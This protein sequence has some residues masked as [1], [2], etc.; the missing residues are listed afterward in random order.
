MSWREVGWV[1]F[2]AG[3]PFA[4][5]LFR[6]LDLWHAQALW[7]QGWAVGLWAISLGKSN[8]VLRPN[9]GLAGFVCWV[10]LYSLFIWVN[11]MKTSKT[12]PLPLLGSLT[13]LLLI[14]FLYQSALT[15]W[16][17]PFIEKLLRVM[18]WVGVIL[19]VYGGLQLLNLD[20]F[21]RGLGTGP[22][23]TKDS[24]VG[25]IGNPSHF[26]VQL[27]MFIPLFLLQPG[28]FWIGCAGA[29]WSLLV[30]TNSIS[31]VVA[32]WLVLGWIIW[33]QARWWGWVG[34][35]GLIGLVGFVIVWTHPSL[36]NP[37]GRWA[38]WTAFGELF[39]KQPLTGFGSGFVMSLSTQTPHG[40]PIFQWRHVHNEY[41][42]VAIEYGLIGLTFI[43]WMIRDLIRDVW[44]LPKT[45]L[46]TA[47]TG[48]LIAFGM[49]AFINF[50]AHL[51]QVGSYALVA[52]CGIRLLAQE[53]V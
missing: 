9:P 8:R 50:P 23:D 15:T 47:L 19:I 30:L 32:G 13:H 21:F 25:T 27:A 12:Y 46:V 2:L 53:P 7:A 44:Q 28:W 34:L 35:W 1:V 17:Q 37:H 14:I 39:A 5:F 43:G 42:Q 26:A 4:H 22:G 33:H 24:L 16:T 11:V 36:L 18:A 49:N 10:G 3:L 41:F 6:P 48:I 38:A 20:Q 29:A 45:K 52:Y 51:W 31:G 40:S